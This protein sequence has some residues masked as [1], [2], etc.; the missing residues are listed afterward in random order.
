VQGEVATLLNSATRESDGVHLSDLYQCVKLSD[1]ISLIGKRIEIDV[2]SIDFQGNSN[3]VVRFLD[4][5]YRGEVLGPTSPLVWSSYT[6]QWSAYGGYSYDGKYR[7]WMANGYNSNLTAIDAFDNKTVALE[8][9]NDRTTKFYLDDTLIGVNDYMFTANVLTNIIIGGN[10]TTSE[11]V[12]DSAPYY[13]QYYN[14]VISG[15]RIKEISLEPSPYDNSLMNYYDFTESLTDVIDVGKEC[16]LHNNARRSDAG[17]NIPS[18]SYLEVKGFVNYFGPD[19]P[20]TVEIDI[21][22]M[23][24]YTGTDHGRFIMFDN[25]CGFVY[26]LNDHWQCYL[27]E[28]CTNEITPPFDMTDPLLFKNSTLTIKTSK[29]NKTFEIYKDN[30]LCWRTTNSPY[31]MGSSYMKKILIGSSYS[32][33]P[34]VIKKVRCYYTPEEE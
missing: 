12:G 34:M 22:D 7:D 16:V 4:T 18:G 3:K 8:F 6:N 11:T 29:R 27:N 31:I 21:G 15:V 10:G 26:R 17:V 28:W 19:Y 24:T 30:V 5:D 14:S 23:V 32:S 13:N 9:P 33:Y 1:N 25:A 2:A 20:I